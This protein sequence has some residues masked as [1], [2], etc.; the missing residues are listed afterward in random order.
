MKSTYRFVSLLSLLFLFYSFNITA[1]NTKKKQKKQNT[2]LNSGTFSGLTFRSIGPALKSGRIADIVIHPSNPNTWYVAAGSGGVWKTENAGTTW[3]PLFDSQPVYSIGCIAVDPVNTHTVWVG[4]GE[5]VG[6]RHV[7]WGNGIYKSTDDGKTWKNLGL[8]HSEHIS[9]IIV[10]P[11]NPDIVWVAAQGPLWNKGGDRGLFKTTDGGKSWQLML[12]GDNEWTG[13]TDIA[14]D[15]R[16]PDIIY[17]A[18]WQRGRTVAAY[19]GGGPGTAIYRSDDGGKSWKKLKNGL[20]HQN[21]GKIGIAISPQKPDVIYAAIELERRSGAVYRSENRGESW[22][23][24]SNTVSGATGPHY[25]QELYASPHQFDRIYLADVRMKVS[26][27]GGKTFKIMAE[28]EK[29]SDNHALAFKKDD[30][31]YL[32]VGCDGGVY[33]SFDLAKSWHYISNLPLTQ[34]YFLALDDSKPFY[35]IYG[36]TQDNNTQVGPS[37]TDNATGIVNSDWIIVQNADGA[38]PAVEPGNPDIAYAQAQ[39]GFLYR[40]DRKTGERTFIQPQPE[41]NEGPERYNWNAPILISPHSP[42]TLY[43]GSHRLWRSND[44]GDSWEAVSGDLTNYQ[45]RLTLPIMD[46]TWSW[47]SP[48]DIYAMS[49]YNT[50]TAIAESPVKKGLLFVGTDDGRIQISENGGEKWHEI[51]VDKIPGVPANAYV[52]D[53]KADLFD[54]NSVYIALDNHKTGDYKP[55]LFKS[56]DRGKTWIS[57]KGDLPDTTIVWRI[58]Q[59]PVK[60]QLLFAATEFGIYFTLNG[61]KNWIK[62][63][64]GLPTISFRDIMIK[65][66]ENDLVC[67]SFGRGFYILDDYSLLR[68]IDESQLEKEALLFKPQNGWWYLP[69]INS[70][71]DQGAS[72]FKAQNPPYGVTFTYYLKNGYKSKKQQRKEKEQKLIKEKKPVTFPGWD[73]VENEFTELSPEIILTVKND[74]GE[75]VRRIKGAINK[76][77]HRITW[78]LRWPNTPVIDCESLGKSQNGNMLM[79]GIMAAPGKYSATLAKVIDGKTTLLAEPVEFEV[80]PL[81]KAALQG[82]PPKE[83]EKFRQD[84][85]KTNRKA[86]IVSGKVNTAYSKI[87][88]MYAAL[89]ASST[90]PGILEEETVAIRDSLIAL[91]HKLYGITAKKIVG[92]KNKPF[93]YSRIMILYQGIGTTTY[94]PTQTLLKTM[95]IINYEVDDINKV[96]T[97]INKEQLPA[98]EQKFNAA[99]IFVE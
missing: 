9:K 60:P 90:E 11:K 27:D 50:I 84:V 1:G 86:R 12:K 2:L 75:V 77:I 73:S 92:E 35:H 83:A 74:N 56:T 51:T 45:E 39:E 14:V 98:L 31:D 6:G 64:G 53:I 59:D 16:N 80:I 7:G 95:E 26:Q 76:G 21:M 22:V 79:S 55:Y 71:A 32:L 54:K 67:A 57:L 5:N 78:D 10:N 58:V 94:G 81:R 97:R 49:T 44:R 41:K 34:F 65:P 20:P 4:T 63:T 37:A 29:H 13:V 24:M 40:I 33:E 69:K 48:W 23:K 52:N 68:E 15:P 61:G 82:A 3:Q 66:E 87:N 85:V 96:I 47:D 42:T 72:F 36:G 62:F 91:R 19:M 28:K 99:G 70:R 18:T 46:K 38:Q 25:Y 88:K 93:V 8:K 89:N 43:F 30:P 17:A